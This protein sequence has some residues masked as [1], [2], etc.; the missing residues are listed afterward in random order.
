MA[1]PFFIVGTERSGSNLLRLVL[2]SHPRLLVPHP[3]HVMNQ[4]GSLEASYGEERFSE[5]ARDVSRFIRW[6]TYPWEV[7]PS[8]V[9]LERTCPSRDLFGLF[10]AAYRACLEHSG[11]AR[12]GCKSTFMIHHASRILRSFPEA[13]FLW[14]VRDPR[15]VAVSARKSVFC[16]FHP[17]H[18]ARLWS[19]EQ[20]VGLELERTLGPRQ[21]LRLHYER[22]VQDPEA[23]VRRLCEFLQEPYEEAML[24][25][26]ESREARRSAS[27]CADWQNTDR[28]FLAG[29]TGRWKGRLRA[30]DLALLEAVAEAEMG[31]LG[32][33]LAT[34]PDE[35]RGLLP[36][37][38]FRLALFGL[39]E[40]VQRVRVEARSLRQDR[41]FPLRARKYLHLLYLRGKAFLRRRTP[42]ASATPP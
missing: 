15:D 22:L 8:G 11:K 27:L 32:Y 16:H 9:D 10:A 37:G 13:R 35:R 17:Y 40:W 29:N 3:P 23:E 30:R 33:P 42:A 21:V 18:V 39:D 31:A 2:N 14:L 1:D 7:T 20:R 38:P 25:F 5:L 12:W 41:N 34:S 6:H 24:S 26:F 19:R 4:L 36:V 28:G